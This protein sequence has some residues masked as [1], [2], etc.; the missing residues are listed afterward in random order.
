MGIFLT[1]HPNNYYSIDIRK[2]FIPFQNYNR[3]KRGADLPWWGRKYFSKNRNKKEKRV[4]IIAQDSYS[5]D[6]GSVVFFSHLFD[7]IGD[8]KEYNEYVGK[9]EQN[10]GAGKFKYR[11][12]LEIKDFIEQCKINRDYLYITDAKKVYDNSKKFNTKF[13]KELLE[14]EISFCNPYLLIILGTAGLK[15]LS[16]QSKYSDVVE[17]GQAI[18]INN[19][20]TVVAPFPIG[21][22][23]TQ[24]NFQHRLNTAISIIRS[25]LAA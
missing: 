3:I 24:K 11:K 17:S 22:G 7:V 8:K 2:K 12:W 25:I 9:I 19:V 18:N 10:F 13:S 16:P 21:Q 23:E 1:K 5:T 15:L 4:M 6:A 20:T 14:Q